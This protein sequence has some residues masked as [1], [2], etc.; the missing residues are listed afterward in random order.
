MREPGQRFSVISAD[1]HFTEP[2]DLW[3]RHLE[4]AYRSRAPHVEHQ[5]DTDVFVCDT[6]EMFPVGMI[7]GVRYKGGDV[8]VQG[9]YADVPPSG[10][11][12]SARLEAMKQDGISAEVLYPTI[13][14]RFYTIEDTPFAAACIRAYNT[15][16][17]E[18]CSADPE[19]FRGIGMVQL[20]DVEAACAEVRR[21]K[22][23]GLA[24]IMIAVH[25][26][27][28]EPYHDERYLPFWAT[29]EALGLPVS[30]HTATERRVRAQLSPA[31]FFL[32][33]ALV[34]PVLIGM[35]YSG[36]FD[37]FPKLQVV[38]VENDAGWAAHTIER[39]DYVDVTARFRNLNSTHLNK[40]APSHYWRNNI[41][42]TFMRDRTAVQNRH[43]IGLDRLMW[44][45][46]FPHGDSTWPDSQ[47]VIDDIFA[48][49]PDDER[50]M[51]LRDNAARLY[52]FSSEAQSQDS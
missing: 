49:V 27:G 31:H 30:L 46:D 8:S 16:A 36:L 3:E 13:A 42:F 50:R 47:K 37:R 17:A 7:H 19:H 38:S 20:D 51:I 45:S 43:A 28:A 44:S 32:H 26:D 23:M 35:I 12:R 21:C 24:G 22:E 40:E 52:G 18:F 5:P 48:G 1:S 6:G 9:R 10:W 11:D 34:Q 41:S 14:M 39:M 15:W 25:P 29:A 2:Q 4:P 33:Y